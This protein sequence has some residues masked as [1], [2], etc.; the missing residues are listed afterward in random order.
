MPLDIVQLPP[1]TDFAPFEWVRDQRAGWTRRGLLTTA[2]EGLAGRQRQRRPRQLPRKPWEKG[3][4]PA[5]ERPLNE[6]QPFAAPE[7]VQP[8]AA[9]EIE[10]RFA[11]QPSVDYDDGSSQYQDEATDGQLGFF[12]PLL[13][14]VGG[15]ITKKLGGKT[16]RAAPVAAP[17]AAPGMDWK[18]V[19]PIVGIGAVLLVVLMKRSGNK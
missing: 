14:M 2:A 7:I 15:A 11:F 12:G 1:G 8:F 18:T 13:K 9:P 5:H 4:R 3:F 17:V 19:L 16:K 6:R 10:N